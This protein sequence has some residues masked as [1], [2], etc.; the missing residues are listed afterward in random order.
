MVDLEI[1]D[2]RL[3]A[4]VAADAAFER[5]ATGFGFTE[6]PVWEPRDACLIFSDIPG[7]RMLRWDEAHGVRL[8]RQPSHMANGN[9][10]DLDGRLVTCE[11][12]TSRVT[13]TEADGRV[14]VLASAYEGKELNSPNDVA[15]APDGTFYFTDPTIGR[16]AGFGGPREPELVVR[17]VYRIDP[18]GTLTRVADDFAQPNGLCFSRGGDRL[19]VNDTERMH[20][21]A[22]SV[23]ADGALDGGA[24][25][26]RLTGTGRGAPDGM[27][28]DA[29]GNV[30]CC[31]P[32]GIHVFDPA[33]DFL[34]VI[35]T[36]EMANNVTWG[37]DD[38]RALFVCALTSVYRLRVLARG[39]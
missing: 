37:G 7:D 27:K 22:F 28:V 6:G 23:A 39:Q 20:I 8:F 38:G 32:G 34:G 16:V 1:H 15:V 35:R 11:H 14:V 10:L 13:R 4:L 21:R 33:G 24:V 26:A 30:W 29:A 9:A 17:G 19:F 31:G 18:G 5:L 12:A 36:P 25:W 2:E 3:R